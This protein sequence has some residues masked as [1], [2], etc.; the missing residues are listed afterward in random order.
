MLYDLRLCDVIYFDVVCACSV[1]PV[2]KL[3]DQFD[4]FTFK[5]KGHME[6]L[7]TRAKRTTGEQGLRYTLSQRHHTIIP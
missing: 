5:D 4:G 2:A 3:K 1:A 6:G 7:R